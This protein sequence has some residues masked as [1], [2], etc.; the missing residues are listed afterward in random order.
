MHAGFHS[1]PV[2]E[3]TDALE[4]RRSLME[5][6]CILDP[7]NS[8]DALEVKVLRSFG[9]DKQRV[10]YVSTS[11]E[12]IKQPPVSHLTPHAHSLG[13]NIGVMQQL[14]GAPHKDKTVVIVKT[15][16]TCQSA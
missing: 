13:G 2:A 9:Q 14:R 1:P 4:H 10:M 12:T 7:L 6:G 3:F 11:Q 16:H 8:L 15:P 5:R